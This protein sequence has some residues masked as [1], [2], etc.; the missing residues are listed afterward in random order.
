MSTV[1]KTDSIQDITDQSIH[2]DQASHNDDSSPQATASN[3]PNASASAINSVAITTPINHPHYPI[4]P[5]ERNEL[6]A[7]CRSKTANHVDDERIVNAKH[8]VCWY[9]MFGELQRYKKKYG[10]C[11]VPQKGSKLGKWGRKMVL[12]Y[13]VLQ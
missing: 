7:F 5:L 12:V 6:P 3:T 1:S 8:N 4:L 2:R 10:H 13:V 9:D 11:L